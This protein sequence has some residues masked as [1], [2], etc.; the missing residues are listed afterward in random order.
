MSSIYFHE[1][2]YCQ[3]ELLPIENLEFCLKQG[4]LINEFANVHKEGI[5]YTDM[6]IRDDN[7]VSMYDKK[8][9]IASLENSLDGIF[10]KFDEVFTGYSSYRKKSKHTNAFGKDEN[11]VMFYDSKHNFV[12]NIWFTLDISKENDIMAA[13]D[14]FISLS[15][16]GEF[17]VAD[18]GWDFIERIDHFD[19]INCYL[20]KRFEEFIKM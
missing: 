2:D 8:I 10:P 5:G 16:L 15:K 12:N 13:Q 6:Y 1:D 9:L 19:K 7:P 20:Q 14:M 3:I 17:I 18:W 11:V 4:G